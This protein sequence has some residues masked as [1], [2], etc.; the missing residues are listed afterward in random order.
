M[1]LPGIRNAE[2]APV[3]GPYEAR[4]RT[5]VAPA[6]WD[7]WLEGSPGEFKR[8]LGWRPARLAPERD[9]RVAGLGQFLVYKTPLVPGSLMY[10]ARGPWLPWEDEGAVRAFF[11][12]VRAFAEQNGVHTVKIE[13]EVREERT[14]TKRLL[15]G[16][17]FGKFRWDLN[18]KTTMLVDLGRS[19]ED[20]LAGKKGKTRYNAR[21]A[22]RKGVRVVEDG[23]PEACRLFWRM[24]EGTPER[25]GFAI[26]RPFSHQSAAWVG[27][28]ARDARGRQGAPV[29]RRARGGRWRP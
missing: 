7:G 9:G 18:F 6:V 4:E 19:E 14:A 10:C 24:F 29:L 17:G 22:A 12:G 20:L 23:S 21:L 15:S 26:R 28:V 2:A 1:S 11:G 27:R 5:G 3:P 25:N 16:M 8:A 13:P